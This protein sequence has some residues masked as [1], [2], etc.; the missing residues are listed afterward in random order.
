MN[1]LSLI[2]VQNPTCFGAGTRATAA[3]LGQHRSEGEQDAGACELADVPSKDCTIA[4]G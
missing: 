1:I 3:D 4:V 2:V